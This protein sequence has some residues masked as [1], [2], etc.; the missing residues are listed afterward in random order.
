MESTRAPSSEGVI[1]SSDQA[2]TRRVYSRSSRIRPKGRHCR[3]GNPRAGP[4]GKPQ[5]SS[6]RPARV[7]PTRRS[8]KALKRRSSGLL[9]E[10]TSKAQE[11][12]GRE[13]GATV[14]GEQLWRGESPR[15]ASIPSGL[16]A[17]AGIRIL[18]GSKALKSRG[19]VIL[20]SSEQKN[21]ISETT[22][23]QRR[24]KAYGSARGKSSAG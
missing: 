9:G 2:D 3:R 4:G 16:R 20:W 19:I 6:V 12:R 22:R 10:R 24:R 7:G 17:L 23:G 13:A 8:G 1:R 11:G 5:E 21:A 18:A 15:R 14:C